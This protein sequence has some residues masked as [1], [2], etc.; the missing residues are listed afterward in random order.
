MRQTRQYSS[1]YKQ[2][3]VQLVKERGCIRTAARELGI[4]HWTLTGWVKKARTK[5]NT[6]RSASGQMTP[7]EEN[8]LLKRQLASLQ[9]DHEILKKAVAVFSQKPKRN[10]DL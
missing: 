9:E 8:R 2:E 4:S 5:V 1:E 10:I 6:E 3:A 7:E